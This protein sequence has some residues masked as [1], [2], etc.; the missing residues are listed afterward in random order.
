MKE[1]VV[2]TS[3]SVYVCV[4]VCVCVCD[5]VGRIRNWQRRRIDF[6]SCYGSNNTAKQTY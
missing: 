3:V 6:L 1:R 5:C 2:R 4:C